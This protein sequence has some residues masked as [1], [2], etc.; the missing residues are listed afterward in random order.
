MTKRIY[1]RKVNAV[2]VRR[3]PHKKWKSISE[4]RKAKAGMESERTEVCKDPMYGKE[5][6]GTLRTAVTSIREFEE[7]TLE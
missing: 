6:V 4:R 2:D 5:Q 7:N 1:R 3:R